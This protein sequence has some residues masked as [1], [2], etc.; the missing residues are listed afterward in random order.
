MGLLGK[1]GPCALTWQKGTGG[2]AL[3]KTEGDVTVVLQETAADIMHDQDGTAPVDGVITGTK[4][5]VTTPLSQATVDILA[6]L[7]AGGALTPV[8]GQDGELEIKTGVGTEML[9]NAYE[10]E[11]KRYVDGIVSTD[12]DDKL[13][14]LKAY[15]VVDASL[16]FGKETQ[17][18]VNVLWRCFPSIDTGDVGVIARFGP[19][20]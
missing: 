4:M 14:I 11:I 12:P 7:L 15:P 9:A 1:L 18:V 2:V 13:T 16:V 5:E 19:S 8:T 20:S 6:E 17:R 3:G 10:L